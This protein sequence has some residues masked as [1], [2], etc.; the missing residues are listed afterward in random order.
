MLLWQVEA[1]KKI[2]DYVTQLRMVGK[3]HGIIYTS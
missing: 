2:A 3:G 1:I